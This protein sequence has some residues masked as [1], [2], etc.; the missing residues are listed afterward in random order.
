MKHRGTS[1]LCALMLASA[2]GAVRA[3]VSEVKIA[4]RYG[5]AY[6]PIFFIYKTSLL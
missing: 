6:L 5:I 4:P 2:A 3:E 1:F